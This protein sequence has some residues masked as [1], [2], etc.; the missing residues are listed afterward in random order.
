M[1]RH[2]AAG[3]G[4]GPVVRICPVSGTVENADATTENAIHDRYSNLENSAQ[5]AT[6]RWFAKNSQCED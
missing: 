2:F 4:P 3:A 1:S 6:A 5:S